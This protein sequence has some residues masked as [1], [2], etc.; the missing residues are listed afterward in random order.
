MTKAILSLLMSL[1]CSG[2]LSAEP[3]APEQSFAGRETMNGYKLTDFKN[4]E[5]DWH[6]VTVR[7]RKDTGE[8]RLTYANDLAWSV[9]KKGEHTYPKGAVFAKI[10]VATH[11]DPAFAS[12]AVP[13]GARRTQFMVRDEKEFARTD[14]W[15][16]ALFDANGLTFPEDPKQTEMAC[17]ACHRIVP[18]RGYVF[19]ESMELPQF[20]L[21][22]STSPAF[23]FED[24][25]VKTLP[26]EIKKQLPGVTQVRMLQGELRK[27]LFQGTLDEIRPVLGHEALRS[28][29][30]AVLAS[31]DGRRF[32]LVKMR[33]KG[34]CADAK[35]QALIGVSNVLFKNNEMLETPFCQR[36]L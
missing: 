35:D 7:F 32:S 34:E 3:Q 22:I 10:G 6:F 18:E 12:S 28:K 19:S 15:G 27:Y 26:P 2:A 31:E 36:K 16:Y 21:K 30:P 11:D 9:L 25:A 4:F 1:V 24:V 5:K 23:A 29:K 14:G 17:A 13:S 20:N 8:M 33:E